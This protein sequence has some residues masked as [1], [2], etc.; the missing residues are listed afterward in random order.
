[1]SSRV[2]GLSAVMPLELKSFADSV[3]Y[4]DRLAA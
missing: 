3:Y 4:T 2:L 1:M